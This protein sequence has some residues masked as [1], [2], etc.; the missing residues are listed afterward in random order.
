MS[1]G[2]ATEMSQAALERAEANRAVSEDDPPICF[3]CNKFM[4]RVSEHKPHYAC[5]QCHPELALAPAGFID[6]EDDDA[7]P[8]GYNIVFEGPIIG[9]NDFK[10]I[11]PTNPSHYQQG[12]IEPIDYIM[13]QG[14]GPNYCRGNIVK[15]VTRYEH[16][17]GVEDLHKAQRYLG[18]LIE[19][20]EKETNGLRGAEDNPV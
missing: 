17:N 7:P 8:M 16:K 20:V 19:A 4:E 15:Y 3:E 12:S 5:T 14:W 2:I 13:A 18:W 1:G 10:N 11:D 6:V 9:F